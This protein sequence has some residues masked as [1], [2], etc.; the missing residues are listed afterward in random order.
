LDVCPNFDTQ[1]EFYR[2][3]KEKQLIKIGC[4]NICSTYK[5]W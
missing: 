2:E 4:K 5:N 1:K 3:H